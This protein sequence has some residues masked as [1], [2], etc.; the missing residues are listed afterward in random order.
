MLTI[1]EMQAR[2]GCT[3][4]AVVNVSPNVQIRVPVKITNARVAW[5]RNDFEVHPIGGSG[6]AWVSLNRLTVDLP[7]PATP[8]AGTETPAA[9]QGDAPA[10]DPVA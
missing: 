8:V 5:G 10:S 9:P 6:V 4:Q 3:A 7:A 2:I 1:N